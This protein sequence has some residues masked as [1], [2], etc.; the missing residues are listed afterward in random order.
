VA[1]VTDVSLVRGAGLGRSC[2]VI[3][4][5]VPVA[6]GRS[7]TLSAALGTTAALIRF[8]ARNLVKK[9]VFDAPEQGGRGGA[10]RG[11]V[12]YARRGG[13]GPPRACAV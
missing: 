7:L 2:V 8:C 12:T 3:E 10:R 1:L 11:N 6:D 4:V 5:A 13:P 9:M